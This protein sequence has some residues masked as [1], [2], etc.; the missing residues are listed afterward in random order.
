MISGILVAVNI[1]IIHVNSKG[2]YFLDVVI[3]SIVHVSD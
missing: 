2:R 1:Q 3:D